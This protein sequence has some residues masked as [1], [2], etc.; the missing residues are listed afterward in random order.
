METTS[1]Q[2]VGEQPTPSQPQTVDP[3][4]ELRDSNGLLFGKY[5]DVN[6]AKQGFWEQN[7]FIGTLVQQNQE[8]QSRVNPAPL[9]QAH[10]TAVDRLAKEGMLPAALLRQAIQEEASRQMESAFRP[11]N[12]TFQA[13]TRL[14]TELPEFIANEAEIMRWVATKPG[15]NQTITG[16]QQAGYSEPALRLAT[17]EWQAQLPGK[18]APVNTAS[19]G[20]PPTAMPQGGARVPETGP[21]R[22]D[23]LAAQAASRMGNEG[24]LAKM[25]FGG[26]DWFGGPGEMQRS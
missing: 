8:L 16:M 18:S 1:S 14:A 17:R 9:A 3:F 24:P 5:A 12:D 15:L 6:A 7:N 25:L 21:T 19:A 20:L 10:E 26:F 22:E 2:P 23:L 11:I 4:A 13:R